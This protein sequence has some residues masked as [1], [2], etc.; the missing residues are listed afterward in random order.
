MVAI[1]V[2]HFMKT[3]TKGNDGYVALKLDIIKVY[4]IMYYDYSRDVMIKM[5]FND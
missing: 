2:I 1:E 3:K 5:G 4:D